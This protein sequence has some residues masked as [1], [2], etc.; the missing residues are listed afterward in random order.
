MSLIFLYNKDKECQNNSEKSN[1]KYVSPTFIDN[2]ISHSKKDCLFCLMFAS[3][4]RI[5]Y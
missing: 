5:F 3:F 1:I 4:L 2:A